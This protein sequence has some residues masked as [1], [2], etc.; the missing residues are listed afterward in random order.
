METMSVL[1]SSK[2]GEG[3]DRAGGAMECV[4]EESCASADTTQQIYMDAVRDFLKARGIKEP[5]GENQ[6]RPAR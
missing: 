3:R 2:V 1:L 6:T 4:A 5:K